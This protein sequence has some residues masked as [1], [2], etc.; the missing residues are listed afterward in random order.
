[1]PLTVRRMV[2]FSRAVYDQTACV[3]GVIAQRATDPMQIDGIQTSGEIAVLVDAETKIREPYAPEVLVDGI[4]AKRNT[5]TKITD[6]P[7]VIALGPGFTAGLD[8]HAVIETMR[9]P[10]L[11]HVI[12]DGSAQANTGIPGD[13]AGCTRERLLRASGDGKMKPIAQIGD[14]V[15]KGDIVAYTGDSPIHAQIDGVIRGMLQAGVPVQTGLKVGDVDPR[16]IRSY[17]Y[18]ISDKAK[19]IGRGVRDAVAALFPNPMHCL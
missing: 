19:C 7:L 6:A 13:I 11:G 1:M 16:A 17:C 5:G 18:A 9:G 15:H 10:E 8:C 4:M 3:D 12:T 14:I 2:S